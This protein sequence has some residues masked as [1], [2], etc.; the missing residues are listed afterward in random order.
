V[1]L[2]KFKPQRKHIPSVAG[3]IGAIVFAIALQKG[4]LDWI[5]NGVVIVGFCVSYILWG[6]WIWTHE[7]LSANQKGLIFVLGV[8]MCV[9]LLGHYVSK[10]TPSVSATEKQPESSS[11]ELPPARPNL[12]TPLELLSFNSSVEISIQNND[13][14]SIYVMDIS[15]QMTFPIASQTVKLGLD[16]EPGK[17]AQQTWKPKLTEYR[18]LGG[19]G[20]NWKENYLISEQRYGQCAF[21]LVYFSPS[22]ISFKQI[23]TQYE[24][25]GDPLIYERASGVLHYRVSGIPETKTQKVPVVAIVTTDSKCLKN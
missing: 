14:I 3:F 17:V 11:K 23:K 15:I 20:K 13:P 7:D 1:C 4:M 24:R 25:D 5:P 8:N 19:I 9:L 12:D 18:A 6:Y 10:Q 2:P 22:D 16:I 21:E